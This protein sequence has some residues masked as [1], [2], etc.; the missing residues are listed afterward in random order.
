MN[1]DKE[2]N[3][4]TDHEFVFNLS[5]GI[6]AFVVKTIVVSLAVVISLNALIANIPDIPKIPENEQNKLILL[7]FIQSP[8]VLWRLSELE[9][10][11]GK[12]ENASKYIETAI[13]LMEMHGSSEKYIERYRDRLKKLNSK[14]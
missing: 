4:S 7:S 6:T 5:H 11:K 3:E 10:A 1:I 2:K 9:E 14:K 12:S 13:G 8:Y